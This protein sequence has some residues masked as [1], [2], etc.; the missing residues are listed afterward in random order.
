ME[1]PK[2][3]IHIRRSSLGGLDSRKP[4]AR[5]P[6]RESSALF[7]KWELPAELLQ[8]YLNEKSNNYVMPAAS[9][10]TSRGSE[11]TGKKS[12][13]QPIK[14][15]LPL[16][17]VVLV[18]LDLGSSGSKQ[19][20]KSEESGSSIASTAATD[21]KSNSSSP[22]A[23]ALASHKAQLPSATNQK[24]ADTVASETT[25]TGESGDE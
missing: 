21:F 8:M 9:A 11:T 18:F 12:R 25:A 24:G 10:T 4:L 22:D 23:S 7:P 5:P 3:S 2:C 16:V 19:S 13:N 6:G 1:F 15:K 20:S 17:N 14:S